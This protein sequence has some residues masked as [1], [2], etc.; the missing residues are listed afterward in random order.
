MGRLSPATGSRAESAAAS[1]ERS[2]RKA[3]E[4]RVMSETL[5]ENRRSPE[6][7]T[8]KTQEEEEPH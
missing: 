4:L 5:P 8:R 6:D 1:P 3:M 7:E 2:A